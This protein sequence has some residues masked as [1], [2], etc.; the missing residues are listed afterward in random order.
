M[1]TE[2]GVEVYYFRSTVQS[3][4]FGFQ[5]LLVF[6]KTPFVLSDGYNAFFASR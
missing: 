6:K 1:I 4:F 2:N 5:F 3:R